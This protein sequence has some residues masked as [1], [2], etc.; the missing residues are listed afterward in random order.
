M[1]YRQKGQYSMCTSRYLHIPN[2]RIFDLLVDLIPYLWINMQDILAKL[3][4]NI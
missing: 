2:M 4:K 3:S 1:P